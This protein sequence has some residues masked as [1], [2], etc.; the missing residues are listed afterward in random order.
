MAFQLRSWFIILAFTHINVTLLF[1]ALIW[2]WTSDYSLEHQV[3][4]NLSYYSQI[5]F[6]VDTHDSVDDFFNFHFIFLIWITSYGLRIRVTWKG[7]GASLRMENYSL[8]RC[9]LYRSASRA[10]YSSLWPS[11][12]KN[13]DSNGCFRYD[14]EPCWRV[15][16][17]YSISRMFKPVDIFDIA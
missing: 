10:S 6:L 17:L 14:S 3:F 7:T 4:L 12:L 16:S 15:H 5:L 1:H 11:D 8:N 13:A 9:V 2:I